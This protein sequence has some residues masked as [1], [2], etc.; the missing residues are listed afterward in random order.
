MEAYENHIQLR[1]QRHYAQHYFLPRKNSR[2]SMKIVGIRFTWHRHT[3]SAS[4]ANK[5]TNLPFP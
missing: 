5:S 2:Q 1:Q 4:D 3:I